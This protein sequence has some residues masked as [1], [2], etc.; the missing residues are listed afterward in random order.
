M[1][2]VSAGG[3]VVLGRE[4]GIG[5]VFL[6]KLSTV[7]MYTD[8]LHRPWFAAICLGVVMTT[9]AHRYPSSP[10]KPHRAQRGGERGAPNSGFR[11]ERGGFGV[12]SERGAGTEG[13]A[14]KAR[15]SK[16]T[17]GR[18]GSAVIDRRY[19]G[20]G[21]QRRGRADARPSEAQRAA[22]ARRS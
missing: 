6:V 15:P 8:A 19:S 2:I 20:G 7:S 4:D 1:V 13:R 22:T 11:R 16:G 12:N 18:N 14:G 17:A 5:M 3:Q 21:P 9:E 10:I